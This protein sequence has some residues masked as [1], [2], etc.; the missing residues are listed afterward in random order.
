MILEVRLLTFS[1]RMCD[2]HCESCIPMPSPAD[3]SRCYIS[4]IRYPDSHVCTICRDGSASAFFN[5]LLKF[6]STIEEEIGIMCACMPF[7]SNIVKNSPT[8]QK[9]FHAVYSLASRALKSSHHGSAT[10]GTRNYQKHVSLDAS[11]EDGLE[12]HRREAT[13]Q[14]VTPESPRKTP[15]MEPGA[16]EGDDRLRFS[17]TKL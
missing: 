16:F 14:A 8:L 10:D 1:Q 4:F 2:E 7:F 17:Y 13:T 11:I 9:Y 5:H 15:R 12:L 3:G 6:Y